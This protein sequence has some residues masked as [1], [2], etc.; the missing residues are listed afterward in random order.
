MWIE[1]YHMLEAKPV[2]ST[3][4]ENCR[5]SSKQ[6]PKTKAE[7]ADMMMVPYASTVG[8]LMYTMVCTRLD[9]G[10]AVRVVSRFMSNPGKEH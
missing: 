7:K 10:Y 9:I 2:G 1:S 5:L 6:S 4:P 3:L 8:S